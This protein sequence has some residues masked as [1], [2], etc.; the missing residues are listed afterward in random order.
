MRRELSFYQDLVV[1]KADAPLNRDL[2]RRKLDVVQDAGIRFIGHDGI[3]GMEIDRNMQAF[4]DFVAKELQT[5]RMRVT[6]FHYAG[7]TYSRDAGEN[8][9][10]LEGMR[11]TVEGFGAWKPRVFVVHVGWLPGKGNDGVL[12]EGRRLETLLGREILMEKIADNLRVF[13]EMAAPLGISLALEN[14]APMICLGTMKDQLEMIRYIGME[15]VGVCL[16]AGHAHMDGQNVVEYVHMAGKNLLETHFHDNVGPAGMP[17]RHPDL[18][19]PVGLGTIHWPGVIDA[20]DEIGYNDPVTF[21]TT[22]FPLETPAEGYRASVQ[23]W[24]MLEDKAR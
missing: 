15:N 12:A 13:A 4:I 22:G 2:V 9:K 8:A 16:D 1:R 6:S 21:E 10:I 20:L 18:H 7:C 23:F 5:R 17:G 19:W 3:G 11:R 24:R 14:V